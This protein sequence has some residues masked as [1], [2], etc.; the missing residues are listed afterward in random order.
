[1]DTKEPLF[2]SH[3]ALEKRKPAR[4][5]LPLGAKIM[6]FWKAHRWSYAF[7]L[8][9]MLMFAIFI[10]IPVIWALII[11]FQHYEFVWD[12]TWAGFSNYVKA[13]TTG[14]GVFVQ[15]IKNT[16]YYTVITVTCNIFIALILAS[17]IQGLSRS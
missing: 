17:L 15:A 4:Q 12:G 3:L 11:S 5:P 16:L 9:S 14:G 13:F 2:M 10:L 6:R 7:I 8:P 1:M